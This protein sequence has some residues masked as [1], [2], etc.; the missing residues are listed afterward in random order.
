MTLGLGFC[1]VLY[2]NR[3]QFGF[4]HNFTFGFGSVLGK[5]PGFR[6]GSFLLGSGSCPS[7]SPID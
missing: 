1:L 7:L 2:G 3:V 6:F 5:K 4:L